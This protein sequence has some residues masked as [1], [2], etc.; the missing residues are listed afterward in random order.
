MLEFV[1]DHTAGPRGRQD[2]KSVEDVWPS[3]LGFFPQLF[4]NTSKPM[5]VPPPLSPTLELHVWAAA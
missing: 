3:V 5:F 2:L 1:Q 4:K